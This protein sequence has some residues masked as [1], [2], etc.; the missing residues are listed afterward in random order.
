MAAEGSQG[1][2]SADGFD[3]NYCPRSFGRKRGLGVHTR[4]AHPNE[5][6]QQALED[7][8]GKTEVKRRRT[9]NEVSSMARWEVEILLHLGNVE[10]MNQ[11]L[12]RKI[13]GRTIEAIKGKRKP[14]AYKNMVLVI[15]NSLASE[16]GEDPESSH[17][18]SSDSSSTKDLPAHPDEDI[19][20]AAD[21]RN[22]YLEES[23]IIYVS[24]ET[25]IHDLNSDRR[26][27]GVL[28]DDEVNLLDEA[29]F[30]IKDTE[31]CKNLLTAFIKL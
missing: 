16:A 27:R 7:L 17:H 5:Y 3:C 4:A 14:P 11:E 20:P 29:F 8:K 22:Y 12:K 31:R 28:T 2:S 18:S 25:Y 9:Q 30:K 10:N 24:S 21:P 26:H 6:H 15:F 13:P 23:A 19:S 1:P